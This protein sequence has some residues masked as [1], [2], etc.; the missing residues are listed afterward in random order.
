MIRNFHEDL[1]YLGY[2]VDTK[3]Y[4]SKLR[5]IYMWIIGFN[6]N[7]QGQ[8]RKSYNL[9]RIYLLNTKKWYF[10][11]KK[12]YNTKNIKSDANNKLN[13]NNFKKI[14]SKLIDFNKKIQKKNTK[15]QA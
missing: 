1:D 15:F 7:S 10:Q 5:H 8:M 2:S 13:F 6:L 9:S 12:N 4:A 11:K 3:I 14:Y